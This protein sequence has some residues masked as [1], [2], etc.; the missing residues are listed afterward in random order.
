MSVLKGS[1][2]RAQVTAGSSCGSLLGCPGEHMTHRTPYL[3]APCNVATPR[4]ETEKLT[5]LSCT[6][7]QRMWAEVAGCRGEEEFSIC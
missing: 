3:T 2:D 6:G 5:H 1:H 7:N 4:K